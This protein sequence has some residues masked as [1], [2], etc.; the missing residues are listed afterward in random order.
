YGP[1]FS[2]PGAALPVKSIPAK[3]DGNHGR[4]V[5]T[6]SDPASR[7]SEKIQAAAK[8]TQ[9]NRICPAFFAAVFA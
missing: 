7:E 8:Q 9:G 4:R 2:C 1:L 5:K 6:P 3:A